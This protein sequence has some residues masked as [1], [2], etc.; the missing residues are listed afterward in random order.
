MD[1]L[2][3]RYSVVISRPRSRDSSALEFIFLRSRSWS[4]D[5]R[6]KVSSNYGEGLELDLEF[7]GKS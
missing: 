1:I 3:V 4:G 5:Q 2:C 7:L 6:V